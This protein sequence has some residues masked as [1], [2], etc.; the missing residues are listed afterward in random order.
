M[1]SVANIQN[2]QRKCI[3]SGLKNNR[4]SDNLRNE[5]KMK[6]LWNIMWR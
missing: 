4:P 5:Q 1:L 6:I 3:F 2:R